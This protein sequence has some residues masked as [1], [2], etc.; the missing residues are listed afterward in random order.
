MN[1]A[2]LAEICGI[3]AGDGYLR[4]DGKR[5]ELDIS[6]SFEEQP[7][8]DRHVIPMFRKLFKIA[9]KGKKFYS[10]RTYGFILRDQ[11]IIKK[12]NEM[13]FP[14]GRKTSLRVPEFIMN[15]NR[16]EK[17]RFMRGLLDTDGC[18]T[19]DRRYSMGYS[20]F[21][22]KYHIYPRITLT[23]IYEDFSRD[24]QR[25][26]WDLGIEQ[27]LQV[28][29][30]K[31]SKEKKKFIIWIRGD[32]RVERWMKLIGSKNP[33]KYSRYKVWKEYGFCPPKT[34]LKERK[35]ILSG[36]LNPK[37]LYGPVAQLDRAS[38]VSS[39]SK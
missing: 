16:I 19:F 36:K 8:Y 5:I 31:K 3:H 32:E 12:F 10:R 33:V 22:R 20:E 26:L 35:Q 9:I 30:P 7:Y 37:M 13:G 1:K 4:N 18:I 17:G 39:S 6:G 27:W 25:L 21:K 28:L 29:V 34:T 38:D 11:K 15:S 23:T 24:L 14:Y 2:D